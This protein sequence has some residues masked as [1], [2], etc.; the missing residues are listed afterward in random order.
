MI[1]LQVNKIE[2][3]KQPKIHKSAITDVASVASRTVACTTCNDRS[4]Q[5]LKIVNHQYNKGARAY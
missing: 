3:L 2:T 5:P 4:K 1:S